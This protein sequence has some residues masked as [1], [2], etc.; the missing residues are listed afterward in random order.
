MGEGGEREGE[1]AEAKARPRR[2]T[3]HEVE[4]WRKERSEMRH[5]NTQEQRHRGG[6]RGRLRAE[7]SPPGCRGYWNC[8]DRPACGDGIGEVNRRN[9]SALATSS[10]RAA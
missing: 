4:L 9:A 7:S 10:A 6:Q 2:T 8:T 3:C 5:D 1:E